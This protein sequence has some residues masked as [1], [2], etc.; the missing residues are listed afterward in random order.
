MYVKMITLINIIYRTIINHK[1]FIN[2]IA[3]QKSVLCLIIIQTRIN[4]SKK[5]FRSYKVR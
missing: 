3:H 4:Q 5:V 2:I 1:L